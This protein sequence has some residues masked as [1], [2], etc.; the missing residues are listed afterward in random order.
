MAERVILH[1]GPRKTGTTYLQTLLWS[2]RD[3]LAEQGVL[4][5]L[6]T[7]GQQVVAFAQE[8]TPHHRP[9]SAELLDRLVRESA[10]HPGTVLVSTELL[11]GIA[12]SRLGELVDRLPADRV[13]VVF[14][15]RDLSH[16]LP[17]EWQQ[18][19]RARSPLSFDDWLDDVARRDDHPFWIS[20]LPDRIVRRWSQVVADEQIRTIVVPPRGAPDDELWRRFAGATGL[21]PEGFAFP[22]GRVNV[23]MGA[24]QADLLRRVNAALG[25]DLPRPGPYQHG[26]NKALIQ[27][28]LLGVEGARS[29][30]VS[31]GHRDWL[32]ARQQHVVDFLVGRRDQVWGDPAELVE[33][34]EFSD[35]PAPDDT[36]VAEEA[37]RVIAD[38]LRR[39][40]ADRLAAEQARTDGAAATGGDSLST[41]LV[42]RL[43]RSVGQVRRRLDG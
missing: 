11:A 7:N 41:D 43:R 36:A 31:A 28:L 27:P 33:A 23:S 10:A 16:Q 26:V 35:E 2:N 20:Q 32:E 14:G 13:E 29:V 8:G 37:V 30:K 39:G 19:V 25:D 1:I 3:R 42:A 6:E 15:V 12:A 38:L 34:L 21:D 17:A 5:P 40:E 24:V 22:A 4:I 9:K 18:W